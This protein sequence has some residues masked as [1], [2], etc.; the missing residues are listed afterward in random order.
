MATNTH[1]ETNTH[2]PKMC[3]SKEMC[4]DRLLVV[5]AEMNNS[6]FVLINVNV[7]N[8]GKE[9]GLLFGCRRQELSQVAPEE[10]LLVGGDWNCTMDF[11]KERNVEELQW[12]C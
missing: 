5:K 2:K 11:T 7:P 8:T 12:G 1:T 9:R 6:G 10:M 4:R 3:S